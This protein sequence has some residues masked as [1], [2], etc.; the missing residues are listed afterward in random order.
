MQPNTSLDRAASLPGKGRLEFSFDD[1]LAD[2][3]ATPEALKGDRL[4]LSASNGVKETRSEFL[5][6]TEKVRAAQTKETSPETTLAPTPPA[7]R[8]PPAVLAQEEAIAKAL[9]G[10]E[11][12]FPTLRGETVV[13]RLTPAD[14]KK[15][16]EAAKVKGYQLTIDATR[17]E[18]TVASGLD[19]K[20]LMAKV[21]EYVSK[22]PAHLRPALKQVHLE[23]APNPQD[24]FWAKT[25]GVP[26]FASAATAGGGAISVWN[27][28]EN[29]YNLNEGV[30]NHEVAHLIGAAYSTS[31]VRHAEMI[32]PGWEDAVRAD[33]NKV[34]EYGTHNANEDFSEAWRYYLDAH[35]TPEAL[36][37]FQEKYPNRSRILEAIYRHEFKG[38]FTISMF[39]PER[40]EVPGGE[41]P[42]LA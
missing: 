17:I 25:Y 12:P 22:V 10:A 18:V 24:D 8:K 28:K 7:V 20:A 38:K 23:N 4:E 33:G 36:K 34:S 9:A 30:F 37:E 40:V 42:R 41:G 32:P 2:L 21:V 39:L 5:T 16:G 11:T 13:V 3:G 19:A 26:D 1:A 29:P 6:I 27:L 31:R 15:S 35:R 14:I